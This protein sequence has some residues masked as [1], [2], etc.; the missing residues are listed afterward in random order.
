MH[1]EQNARYKLVHLELILL[2]IL[3]DELYHIVHFFGDGNFTLDEFQE[4]FV[5]GALSL[6]VLPEEPLLDF[7][8]DFDGFLISLVVAVF[9]IEL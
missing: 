7:W 8:D 4:H 1:V 6:E 5:G 3:A 2:I 9:L